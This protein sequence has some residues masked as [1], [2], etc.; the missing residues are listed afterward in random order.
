MHLVQFF[1]IF[2]C[3]GSSIL[4]KSHLLWWFSNCKSEF[5]DKYDSDLLISEGYLPL[6]FFLP[7]IYAWEQVSPFAVVNQV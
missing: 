6:H 5:S 2:V 7:F 1:R 3:L 4:N